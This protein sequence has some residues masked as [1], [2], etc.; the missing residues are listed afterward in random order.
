MASDH[1]LRYLIEGTKR[2]SRIQIRPRTQ[3]DSLREYIFTI[4]KDYFADLVPASKYL[5]ILKV[6]ISTTNVTSPRLSPMCLLD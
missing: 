6:R 5:T 1:V 2:P 4:E 3:V